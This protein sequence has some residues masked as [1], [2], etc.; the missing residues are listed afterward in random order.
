MHEQERQQH[1]RH[2]VPR[3]P[4]EEPHRRREQHSP[5]DVT[6]FGERLREVVPPRRHAEFVHVGVQDIL[7]QVV[8]RHERPLA[9]EPVIG[10][11]S[12]G[13]RETDARNH[14]GEEPPTAVVD[15][16]P[17][18]VPG[19][20]EARLITHRER[21]P[22]DQTQRRPPPELALPGRL[23]ATQRERREQDEQVT[24]EQLRREMHVQ[25][26]HAPEEETRKQ[27]PPPAALRAQ[28]SVHRAEQDDQHGRREGRAQQLQQ[29]HQRERRIQSRGEQQASQRPGD[30][31]LYARPHHGV[32]LPRH[33]IR[34][35]RAE[36]LQAGVL[37]NLEMFVGMVEAPAEQGEQQREKHPG[38]H[39][40]A[41][42]PPLGGVN[43][44]GVHAPR[45]S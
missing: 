36:K 14:P 29:C 18:P 15:Q 8:E 11:E 2:D 30:E 42:A 34:R 31:G 20:C 32:I 3:P 21:Q 13:Q 40:P 22:R 17:D 12:R 41:G 24:R 10:A 6:A 7:A 4:D 37:E 44:R 26:G 45:K 28:L 5:R 16:Q 35:L 39:D 27:E 33:V 23:P 9:V 38:Q 25:V 19:Q 43:R 1:P